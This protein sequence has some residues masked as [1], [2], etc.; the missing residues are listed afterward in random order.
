M[1]ASNAQDPR[2]GLRAMW[3]LPAAWRVLRL[4]ARPLS[5]APPAPDAFED[6]LADPRGHTAVVANM[7]GRLLGLSAGKS[8][9]A[10]W[11]AQTARFC[12]SFPGTFG[13][14]LG[15][16]PAAAGDGDGGGGGDGGDAT[17][18]PELEVEDVAEESGAY[19]PAPPIVFKT[20]DEYA[21]LTPPVRLLLLY[22][23]AELVICEND[24]LLMAG[25]MADT[26][27]DEMRLE[28]VGHDALGSAYWYFGDELRLYRE[29][30]QRKARARE[31]VIAEAKRRDTAAA[32]AAAQEEARTE[33]E[34]R[35]ERSRRA[36][37]ERWAPRVAARRSTRASRA[38]EEELLR[39]EDVAVK[40]KGGD[41]KDE[42]GG[43]ESEE[44][45]ESEE[46][47]EDEE[48]EEEAAAS[49]DF[50][51]APQRA[52]SRR[53]STR[54][55]S[56]E[57][58]EA[59]PQRM[60]SRKRQPPP[61]MPP[62]VT[63]ASPARKRRR[64]TSAPKV[65]ADPDLRRCDGWELVCSGP[66]ELAAFIGRFGARQD[67]SH[68]AE[69]VLVRRLAEELLPIVREVHERVAR[70]EERRLRAEW[71]ASNQK[72]S[73]RVEA[74]ERRREEEE[75]VAAE[76]ATQEAALE[77]ARA[78]R[79][80]WLAGHVKRLEK[81][82]TREISR[83]RRRKLDSQHGAAPAAAADAGEMGGARRRR[84]AAALAAVLAAG[85]TVG[86]GEDAEQ[87]A[88]ALGATG[89]AATPAAGAPAAMPNQS[90]V[91][92]STTAGD[93]DPSVTRDSAAA[94][95][96]AVPGGDAA[97]AEAEVNAKSK[98]VR[99]T[100]GAGGGVLP[101]AEA[102]A[103]VQH[104]D[105]DAAAPAKAAAPA[106]DPVAKSVLESASL[107]SAL[108]GELT[109]Q[110]LPD[111][112]LPTRLLTSFV[113]LKRA[114]L[115][116]V[117]LEELLA[118]GDGSPPRP[119]V[120]GYGVVVP[121][122]GVES[123][124]VCVELGRVLEW[125]IEYAKHPRLW[126]KTACAW[127]E[128]QESLPEYAKTFSSARSKYEICVRLSILGQLMKGEQLT[129][130]AVCDLLSQRY[131]HM[132]AYKEADILAEA[133]FVLE[134]M[135]MLGKPAL[136]R[137]GFI[138][139]L[140][141][142]EADLLRAAE[143]E[144]QSEVREQERVKQAE[145]RR[146]QREA[147]KERIANYKREVAL[148]KARKAEEVQR[149]R[150]ASNATRRSPVKPHG[151]P[152]PA[153]VASCSAAAPAPAPTA[154]LSAAPAAAAIAAPG[155]RTDAPALGSGL[156]TVANGGGLSVAKPVVVHRLTAAAP[157]STA[158][159]P[160]PQVLVSTSIALASAPEPVAARP[161][162]AAAPDASATPSPAAVAP[163]A[164]GLPSVPEVP[165]PAP[166]PAP[167]A[168]STAPLAAS[169]AC[170][171]VSAPPRSEQLADVQ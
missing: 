6:A 61:A 106:P 101:A 154:S 76:A 34:E 123:P 2:L 158:V 167:A 99:A 77:R 171:G 128:L 130:G 163:A 27:V 136:L 83:A 93:S 19:F 29:P 54:R 7:H 46:E 86:E 43:E 23:M 134:Q 85:G 78:E 169:G 82:L 50:P 118:R 144:L 155:A 56:L 100:A 72:K 104:E 96:E 38:M 75:A 156:P 8:S 117:K 95:T 127:Y 119:D 13:V 60:S 108:P 94:P 124:P 58:T 137:S 33:R 47:E 115:S 152:T 139:A 138:R 111:E 126:V 42:A 114:D 142:G 135:A 64:S 71:L 22:A 150:K 74:L 68:A 67:I 147:E 131:L 48:E 4:L 31:A 30:D 10:R 40:V 97:T 151:G 14:I 107:E 133:R 80:A 32:A 146:R 102:D 24:T 103:L 65:F 63:V 39:G 140:K 87:D 145:A 132:R 69:R 161:A 51:A 157:A 25:T 73:S 18:Q 153:A 148:E 168:L 52:G 62:L 20:L 45:E 84:R 37:A 109:W 55:I 15:T 12:R 98:D 17:E 79:E 21:A 26:P 166:A 141:K 105:S 129:Y 113:F 122:A 159:S 143:R 149:R 59:A 49:D 120:M 116:D 16:A 121:P 41:K 170:N 1:A 66:E 89:Y 28:P 53:R 110:F 3:Q 92:S 70:E 112:Q 160:R 165:G 35:R 164:A 36:R 57:L 44:S 81:S 90:P 11:I 125:Q 91:E 162:P 9:E 5:H 88:G